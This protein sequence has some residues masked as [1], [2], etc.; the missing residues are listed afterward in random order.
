VKS[1]EGSVMDPERWE[2]IK[3]VLES[4]LA[5]EPGDRP[6]FLEQT[7]DGDEELRREVESLLEAHAE[8]GGFIDAPAV[9]VA[10]QMMAEDQTPLIV[11]A[12][13]G[14]YKILDRLGAGGMGEVYLAQD[15]RLGRKVALKLMPRYFAQDAGR[16]R[17][18]KQE[19]RA[20]SA[21][22]HPHVATIYEIGEAE[23]GTY[24]AMEYVE[25][26]TVG[27]KIQGR[28]LETKEILEI[29][30]QV[31]DALDAAHSKGVIHRDI[32][33]ANIMVTERVQ[34]KVLDFGLAKIA[35]ANL[36]SWVTAT[37]PAAVTEPGMVMGTIDYMSPEQAL[38]KELDQRTDLFSLGVVMYE[39]ATGRLPFSGSTPTET[40][41]RITHTPP[42]AIARFN[43]E[44]P[45]ELERIIRK[46]LEK[47]RERRYQTAR[48]LLV[49]LRNLKRDSDSGAVVTSAVGLHDPIR[50]WL[51]FGLGLVLVVSVGIG[52]YLFVGGNRAAEKSVSSMVV[53]PFVNTNGDPNSEYVSDG[54]TESLINSLSRLPGLKVMARTTAF[55]YK[56]RESDPQAV[57][58]ELKVDVV[59]TGKVIQ[60]GE[61]LILQADL[62]NVA[63][64]AEIWGEKYNRRLSDIFGVQEEIAGEISGKLGL[65]LSGEDKK[66][67]SK[68]YTE[69]TEAYQLYLKGRYYWNKRTPETIK[70][71]IEYF[72]QAT[73]KDPG[74]ALAFAGMADAYASLP[75]TSDVPPKDA[76]PKA[77]QAAARALEIDDGLAEAHSPMGFVTFWFDRDWARGESHYKRS[78][79]I[80]P[81]YPYSRFEYAICLSI[82]GRF[83]EAMIEAR[84]ALELDPLSLANNSLTGQILFHARQYDQAIDQLQKA[85]EI[86][87]N[88]WIA[89]MVL[90]KVY[91]QKR[92]YRDAID[93]LQKAFKFSEG[94]TE[95]ISLM[96]YTY[97]VSGQREQAEKLLGELKASSKERYV[98]ASNVALVYAGLGE[99]NQALDWLDKAFDERDVHVLLLKAVPH[100]DGIRTDPR[101]TRLLQRIGFPR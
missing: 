64:G 83:E 29:A 12:S 69:S 20:A 11:G 75:I 76:F 6:A 72:Q 81:N 99:T 41:D 7:C 97:A 21:L 66:L 14:P 80:N 2:Q 98:P 22:S 15:S 4:L 45:G 77:K 24:I 57:G 39:M 94:N 44:V 56:G 74:Y 26:Q 1:I 90:G 87:P 71:A 3:K 46:C 30:A 54:I 101:F 79:E 65:R 78:I 17:R 68:R 42:E 55:R 61:R 50:R 96:G 27:S 18:F 36:K 73:E 70:R 63:D 10:A 19:A 5:R 35:A 86:E 16:V 52:T 49:D 93:E 82:L 34:A 95:A 13:L 9:E 43:Y 23:A 53:L 92:M 100:W 31:A 60:Q 84:R 62:V 8:V 32:K 51:L 88:F 28:P 48:E 59:M 40:I 89:H 58:R 38:G 25:G 67:L 33:S 37:S 85:I 91:V 47:D